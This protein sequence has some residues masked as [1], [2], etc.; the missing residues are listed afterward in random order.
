MFS[1]IKCCVYVMQIYLKIVC[2][3]KRLDIKK[4]IKNDNKMYWFCVFL[5]FNYLIKNN[6][7]MYKYVVLFLCL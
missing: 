4:M 5:Y 1:L 7:L 6:R 3:L 2:G